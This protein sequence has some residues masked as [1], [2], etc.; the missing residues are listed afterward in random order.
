MSTA[1]QDLERQVDALTTAGIPEKLIYLDRKSGATTDRP[2]LRAALGYARAGDVICGAHPG[3]A[4]PH[5]AGHLEP[6]P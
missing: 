1:K 3:P 4:G 5:S 6:D 2:G